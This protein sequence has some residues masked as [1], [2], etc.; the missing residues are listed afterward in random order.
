MKR[1]TKAFFATLVLCSQAAHSSGIPTV[2]VA[3]LAQMALNAQQQAQEALAQLNAAKQAIE[4][5]KSQY[6][7]YKGLMTG[8]AKLGDFL[9]NP[10][11]NSVLPVGEWGSI[12]SNA[13]NLSSLRSRYGLTSSDPGVQGMF[14]KLLSQA[15]LLED[16]YDASNQ[17]VENASKLR[18][19]LN[20]VKTPQ[21]REDLNLRFQQEQLELTNTSMRL[22]NM[23]MLMEQQQQ[24]D[25]KKKGQAMWGKLSR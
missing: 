25:D 19:M 9:N 12:Y 6:E 20:T 1:M 21:E 17:R 15:G 2:D 13:K 10:S 7:E 22:Q 5:A 16:A 18:S 4:Q 3:G 14:D 23:K 24:I 8:N 11:L